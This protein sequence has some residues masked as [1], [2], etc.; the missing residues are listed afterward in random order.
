MDTVE[1]ARCELAVSTLIEDFFG[2]SAALGEGRS[3]GTLHGNVGFLTVDIHFENLDLASVD[4]R[5]DD[6][7]AGIERFV[8]VGATGLENGFVNGLAGFHET[9]TE[10]G[11]LVELKVATAKVEFVLVVASCELF[12][13]ASMRGGEGRLENNLGGATA[14]IKDSGGRDVLDGTN[15]AKEVV[16]GDPGVDT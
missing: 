8:L 7:L 1:R 11:V 6:G 14:E 12:G 5:V 3:G 2:E 4:A 13:H 10:M 9:E 15:L 16:G